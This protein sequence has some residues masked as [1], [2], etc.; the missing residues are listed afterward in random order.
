ME[1]QCWICN[2]P[3]DSG[4]HKFK[5]SDLVT[6][7]GEGP[8]SGDKELLHLK[9]G[10]LRKIRGPN[11]QIVKYEKSLCQRCND[12]LS[13]PFDYAYDQ[14]IQWVMQNQDFVIRRRIINFAHIYGEAM[15]LSQ[16]NLYKYF[17]KSF[18]C[19]L[20][21]DGFNV[22]ADVAQLI[23]L[24]GFSTG[25]RITLAVNEDM[26]GL[27]EDR[28]MGLYKG[29]LFGHDLETDTPVYI[30]NEGYRWLKIFYWY[31]YW[32]KGEL[33]FPWV[34]DSQFLYLG[35]FTLLDSEWHS[36]LIHRIGEFNKFWV[37]SMK[38]YEEQ[39]K[40]ESS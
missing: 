25:L 16:R 4:E 24:E 21:N 36:E 14:F 34:A 18:G 23:N 2:S 15:E 20:V 29:D 19:R 8:Y 3:A 10:V 13:Q 9:G 39:H 31:N 5:K 37:E 40:D 35:T 27:S 26:M 1:K 6:L 12:T 11:A 28:R 33:G 32:P 17:A 22:P 38:K 7:H 30:W